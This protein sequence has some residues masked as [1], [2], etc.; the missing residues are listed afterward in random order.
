MERVDEWKVDSLHPHTPRPHTWKRRKR[1]RKLPN[2][3]YVTSMVSGGRPGTFFIPEAILGGPHGSTCWLGEA[4]LY[5][6]GRFYPSPPVECGEG[7]RVCSAPSWVG[8]L[9]R[10][11]VPPSPQ[12]TPHSWL[13]PSGRNWDPTTQPGGP[14]WTCFPLPT[15]PPRLAPFPTLL[16]SGSLPR[17]PCSV[18]AG[19]N[20]CRTQT[21]PL[22]QKQA[23]TCDV[24]G[25]RTD[26]W[27]SQAGFE[28]QP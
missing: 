17:L 26:F 3:L 22:A 25:E 21:F 23:R 5:W 18:T 13:A 12:V 19:M 16:V 20:D 7:R 4:G 8:R 1:R 9:R 10:W 28:S 15:P 27:G 24:V 2:C 6:F 14:L 11:P